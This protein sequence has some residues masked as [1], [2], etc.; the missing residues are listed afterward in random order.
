MMKGGMGGRRQKS[1]LKHWKNTGV[2]DNEKVTVLHL[3]H[4]VKKFV[5]EGRS[6]GDVTPSPRKGIVVAT[7]AWC[8]LLKH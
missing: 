1:S 2:G 7:A 6:W 4:E 8:W 3:E 5:L